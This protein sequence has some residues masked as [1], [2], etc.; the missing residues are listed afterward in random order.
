M[1][2]I[3]NDTTTTTST[4]TLR[5]WKYYIN[6]L[7]TLTVWDNFVEHKLKKDLETALAGLLHSIS[8]CII[9]ILI[10]MLKR[11]WPMQINEE[12][13]KVTLP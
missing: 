3:Q 2:I 1:K 5:R 10:I 4:T 9:H 8:A 11:Q 6:R 13:I 12:T 7:I